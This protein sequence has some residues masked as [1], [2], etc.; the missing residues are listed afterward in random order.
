MSFNVGD[1][2][3]NSPHLFADLA[4]LILIVG[5][6][7]RDF[8]HLNDLETLLI[9]NTVAFDEIDSEEKEILQ[10]S[11]SA[12]VNS[13][14][15]KQL[16]DV[17]SQLSYR[18]NTFAEYYP[19][20]FKNSTLSLYA[21]LTEKQR[22]YRQLLCC[23]RLRSFESKSGVRQKWAMSFAEISKIA[24]CG[25]SPPAAKV[26]LFDANS[27]DR[28]IYYGTDLRVALKKLGKDLGV[29]QIFDDHCNKVNPS[30]D[31]GIDIVSVLDF[32]D[33]AATNY[34]ILGQCAAQE[35]NWPAKRFESMFMFLS[36]YFS[37]EIDFFSVIFIPISFRNSNGEWSDFRYNCGSLI[38][39]RKRMLHLFGAQNLDLNV[40]ITS[41]W[42]RD[43]ESELSSMV[44]QIKNGN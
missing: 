12:A 11:C 3:P 14:R 28:K 30:G 9:N 35:K 40:I 33:G 20:N 34:A 25:L 39:D 32:N 36:P 15:D 41:D 22:I 44:K 37:R 1:L 5:H 2:S 24:M 26:R 4:E 17:M 6:F 19:F 21:D 16:E 38:I 8:L 43:F 42:F 31:A 13:R 29:S 18:F 10:E 27:T 23:S 7:G